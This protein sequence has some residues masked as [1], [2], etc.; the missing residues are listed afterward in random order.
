MWLVIDGH[1]YAI[2]LS[3]LVRYNHEQI[4]KLKLFVSRR[5]KVILGLP[6]LQDY[7]A[8]FDYENKRVGL[9]P[10]YLQ[11]EKSFKPWITELDAQVD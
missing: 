7:Y 6:F 1:R 2:S 4:I 3:K 10:S 5:N 8:V 11:K 9:A